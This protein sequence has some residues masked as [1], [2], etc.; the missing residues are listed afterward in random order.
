M[1]EQIKREDLHRLPRPTWAYRSSGSAASQAQSTTTGRHGTPPA[2]RSRTRARSPTVE[3]TG[4]ARHDAQQGR[5]RWTSQSR[6]LAHG[7]RG[8][9]LLVARR[10]N[11][12]TTTRRGLPPATD[13][14]VVRERSNNSST[15]PQII[16]G[17][18]VAECQPALAPRSAAM[19]F[20]RG[21]FGSTNAD[22]FTIG[23]VEFLSSTRPDVSD[24]STR[25]LQLRPTGR[26]S[27]R[28][29]S[30]RESSLTA[31]ENEELRRFGGL[32]AGDDGYADALRRQPGLGARAYHVVQGGSRAFDR[33]HR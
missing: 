30:S 29:P 16:V 23:P 1:G 26:R 17:S 22:V 5:A 33:R 20:T 31:H 4:R 24:S 27:S 12:G 3:A 32:D 9:A 19:C 15:V 28:S 18:G 6:R 10:G 21:P 13:D 11:E 2:P 14:D 25:R 7:D 8:Q